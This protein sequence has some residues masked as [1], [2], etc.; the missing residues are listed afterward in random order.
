[1]ARGRYCWQIL[2]PQRREAAAG[3]CG[4][5][6]SECFFRPGSDH[7]L[8]IMHFNIQGA[9]GKLA[10]LKCVL[11][12]GR[13]DILCVSEHWAETDIT[14]I[15]FG[16]YRVV[17]SYHRAQHKRGGVLIA[18][19][20][21]YCNSVSVIANI[22]C[23]EKVFECCAVDIDMGGMKLTIISVY[24][25]PKSD[26]NLFLEMLAVILDRV[27]RLDRMVIL[28]GDIN[29]DMLPNSS[30]K[31]A[32]VFLS[33]LLEYNLRQ[34]IFVPTRIT[35]SSASCIDG[36][37]T[38]CRER[39]VS[40]VDSPLS[41]HTYQTMTLKLKVDRGADATVVRRRLING[42]GEAMFRAELECVDWHLLLMGLSGRGAFEAFY[43][44][45]L[46]VFDKSFPTC[47]SHTSYK[48]E[49]RNWKTAKT[50]R[51]GTFVREMSILSRS[52][53]NPVYA[54]R[55]K[56]LK[57][58]YMENVVREKRSYN[59]ERIINSDNYSKECWRIINDSRGKHHSNKIGHIRDAE[60]VFI[61]QTALVCEKFN[62]YFSGINNKTKPLS[63]GDSA[64]DVCRPGVRCQRSFFLFPTT[65]DEV[66]TIIGRVCRKRSCGSDGIPGHIL[67]RSSDLLAGA[68][69]ELINHSFCEGSYPGQ[70]RESKVVPIYKGKGDRADMVNYR[71]LSLQSN[72]AKIF[73]YAFNVR[74]SGYL[75]KFELLDKC[76]SGFRPKHS[77]ATALTLAIDCVHSALNGKRCILGIF[78]DMS[79]AFDTVDC[80]LLI[81]KLE[82]LG[83]RGPAL[84]WVKSYLS[85]RVQRVVIDGVESRPCR[86]MGGT[87]QGSCLSPTLFNV[88]MSDLPAQLRRAGGVPVIYADD[89]SVLVTGESEPE[90]N[91]LVGSVVRAM[92]AWC[93][94]N[95]LTLNITKS[96]VLQ[97]Y[98]KNGT[99][100]SSILVRSEGRTVRSVPCAGFLGVTL[101]QKL[102]WCEHIGKLAAK[103]SGYV[104]L[105]RNIRRTVTADV[106]RLLYFGLVQSSIAYGLIHW[107]LAREATRIFV[108]QKKLIRCMCGLARGAHCKPYFKSARILTVP[109]LYI[110]LCC[111]F[112]KA[113]HRV[114]RREHVHDHDV[115]SK[116]NLIMPFSRLAIGQQNPYYIGIKYLNQLK[117][118]DGKFDGLTLNTFKHR[119]SNFL[120]DKCYY[121]VDE[122]MT[123]EVGVTAGN[124]PE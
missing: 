8:C 5:R 29:V 94:Q 124:L 16:N 37:F 58:L 51:L 91:G 116:G 63:G 112:I 17:C 3:Y 40:V 87:P 109:S 20:R 64:A 108:I 32:K 83:I 31:D 86:V 56:E 47:H 62:T 26:F 80:G 60:G 41:D 18:V 98:P 68:I 52:V 92:T 38:G 82:K 85:D 70:L 34:T 50:R 117:K 61:T 57:R 69:S 36:I 100:N 120:I 88:F 48:D 15:Q 30:D 54:V 27:C 24:R 106:L 44:T 39:D 113:N 9:S 89:T 35:R 1:M 2:F 25:S 99:I 73:E 78:F 79:R 55:C 22:S 107:G 121:T 6:G 103:L 111:V 23:S 46:G 66:E 110:Y 45:L 72:I 59:N 105:I 43:E 33:M 19:K 123:D 42:N 81:P 114:G 13:V 90:L 11:D 7:R 4:S 71:P 21:E 65:A 95:G 118:L 76:Q 14:G 74:L 10:E 75:E 97:F 104:F 119:L 12:D 67:R 28:C 102:T 115:R 93:R 84:D 53:N 101:D 49:K 96:V 122:F 77:T